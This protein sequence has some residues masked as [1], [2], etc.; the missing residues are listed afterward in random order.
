MAAKTTTTFNYH[1]FDVFTIPKEEFWKNYKRTELKY[2]DPD[3][4]FGAPKYDYFLYLSMEEKERR[5]S[6]RPYILIHTKKSLEHMRP[7]VK[8]N[9]RTVMRKQHEIS[10]DEVE[11][12]DLVIVACDHKSGSAIGD[13]SASIFF[14]RRE[15]HA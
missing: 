9:V 3:G 2:H 10:I 6:S 12:E 11:E 15:N 8:T 5:G 13:N 14:Q 7:D 1:R 4:H